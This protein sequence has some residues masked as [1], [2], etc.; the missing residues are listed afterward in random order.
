MAL[1]AKER[2]QLMVSIF[3]SS[4]ITGVKTTAND[5]ALLKLDRELNLS[6]KDANTL[7]LP[8]A[9][10]QYDRSSCT[11]AGWGDRRKFYCHTICFIN[12]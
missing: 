9:K 12:I 3:Y 4:I 1:F 11:I 6:H 5:I 10:Q 2:R 8:T 7:C